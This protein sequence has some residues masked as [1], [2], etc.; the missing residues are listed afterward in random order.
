M[1]SPSI[2]PC[3]DQCD[4]RETTIAVLLAG[5]LSRPLPFSCLYWHRALPSM[6]LQEEIII[7]RK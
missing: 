1:A 3:E 7:E 2:R 5:Q 4:A 6:G